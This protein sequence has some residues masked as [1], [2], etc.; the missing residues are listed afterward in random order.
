MNGGGRFPWVVGGDSHGWV[1]GDSEGDFGWRPENY[2]TDVP[3]NGVRGRSQTVGFGGC[4][5]RGAMSEGKVA[6]T[7]GGDGR[8]VTVAEGRG[9]DDRG[10]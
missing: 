3:Q 9:G 10:A 2:K 7:T 4:R 8:Q 5:S 1:G 6:I